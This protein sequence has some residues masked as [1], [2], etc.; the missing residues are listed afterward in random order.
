MVSLYLLVHGQSPTRL[1]LDFVF[2]NSYRQIEIPLGVLDAI[3]LIWTI[4]LESI[5][6]NQP[7]PKQ[8]KW[9]PTTLN[10]NESGRLIVTVWW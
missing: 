10:S 5:T 2:N 8:L 7:P 6:H 3:A 1:P 4:H 9:W